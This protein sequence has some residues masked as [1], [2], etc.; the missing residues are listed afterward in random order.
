MIVAAAQTKPFKNNI[1]ENILDHLRLIELA[2][3]K[4]VQPKSRN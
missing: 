2:A 4:G 3:Q 1:Q